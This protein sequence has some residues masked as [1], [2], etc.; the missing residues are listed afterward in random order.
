M[1]GIH[2]IFPLCSFACFTCSVHEEQEC[3][4]CAVLWKGDCF[5]HFSSRKSK[6]AVTDRKHLFIRTDSLKVAAAACTNSRTTEP[7][8]ICLFHTPIP[9]KNIHSSSTDRG[10]TAFPYVVP[11]R[12]GSINLSLVSRLSYTSNVLESFP[13]SAAPHCCSRSWNSTMENNKAFLLD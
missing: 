2:F 1:P 9:K 3:Y 4:M 8:H 12:H 7:I 13:Q 11:C 6:E 10:I 5:L